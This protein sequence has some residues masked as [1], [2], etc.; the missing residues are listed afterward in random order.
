MWCSALGCIVTLIL[1][2]LAMPLAADAQPAAKIPRVGVLRPGNPPPPTMASGRRT[3][4]CCGGGLNQ[5]Q[6]LAADALQRP[7]RSPSQARLK[8]GR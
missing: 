6:R 5:Y 7:R 2:L 3:G 8:P 4:V 1:S